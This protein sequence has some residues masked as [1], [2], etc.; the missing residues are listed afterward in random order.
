AFPLQK[1]ARIYR[2]LGGGVFDSPV[3]LFRTTK[4]LSPLSVD[5][6]DFNGDGQLDLAVADETPKIYLNN[7]GTF[8]QS[9]PLQAETV[10][11]QVWSMRAATADLGGN[12]SL[13]L[14]NRDAPSLLFS[15]FAP[16]LASSLTPV[17]SKPAGSLAWGDA[18]KNGTMDLLLGAGPS[19]AQGT[20]LYYNNGGQY[21]TKL[22]IS[23]GLGPQSVAFGDVNGDGR[24]DIAV[25]T[26][27]ENR[28][29][30]AGHNVPDWTASAPNFPT[31][32]VAFIDA[33]S[34]GKLDLLAGANGAGVALYLNTGSML[35]STPVFVT[36]EPGNV[37][38][39]AVAD[40][41]QDFYLDFAVAFYNQPVRLYRNNHNNTFTSV[42]DSGTH[43]QTTSLAW[44]DYNHDGYADL[45]VGNFEQGTQVYENLNGSLPANHQP[46]WTSPTAYRTT[47]IAWGDW[48]YDGYADL[49]IGNDNQPTQVFGNF[50]SSVGLPRLFWL[51][52]SDDAYQTTG[53]AWGD[54]DGDGDLDLGLSQK[55]SGG[56]SGFYKNGNITPSHLNNSFVPTL[57]LPNNPS[58]VAIQRPGQTADGYLYSTSELLGGPAQPTVTVHYT[59]Y[60]PDGSRKSVDLDAAGNNIA[61][62]VF[63]FSLDGGSTWKT[64]S[65]AAGWPGAATATSRL[66]QD[67]T[68]A[69]DI[70]KDQAISDD[71]RFRVR[72]VPGIP[73]GPVQRASTTAVSP[74]FRVRGVTCGWPDNPTF[75]VSPSTLPIGT[76]GTFVGAISNGAGQVTFRWN[77]GDGS[78]EVLGQVAQHA[79]TNNGTFDVTLTVTGQPCPKNREVIAVKPVIAGTGQANTRLYL[80][81]LTNLGANDLAAAGASLLMGAS[82]PPV[83]APQQPAPSGGAT[84]AARGQA[85]PLQTTGAA[86]SAP[87]VLA[88]GSITFTQVTSTN[89]GINNEPSLNGNG[90]R[91]A[92]WSTADLTGGNPDGNIEVFLL[93]LDSG[94]ITFTQISNSTGS[95]LGGFNLSPS[96]DDAG[97][98]IA[99]FS[100]RDL[101]GGNPDNN[102]EIF[103]YAVATGLLS[104]VTQT[105]KGYNILPAMSGNGQYI[106]FVSDRN[107]VGTNTDGNIEVFR[108]KIQGGG[109]SYTQVTSTTGGVTD[110]PSINGDGTR[111]AFI[112][113]QNLDA[114]HPNNADN[115]REVFLAT[116]GQGGQVSFTQIS[117]TTSGSVGA[118]SID[119]AGSRVTFVSNRAPGPLVSNPASVREVFLA[120]IGGGGSF[121]L[122]RVTTTTVEL[123]NDQPSISADGTRIGFVSPGIGQVRV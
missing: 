74:P 69:W 117:Q 99:F 63:E 68:F 66:G 112:S 26:A 76:T 28:L 104:Q 21:P 96:I 30:L 42:W 110:E 51:W 54:Y 34:D 58:Y 64:A 95:I 72:I 29:Y 14:T 119:G 10:T 53:M 88:A 56:S 1:E 7:L 48:D 38:A 52:S 5:W 75:S 27:V 23:S 31:H 80:P 32:Q 102:F 6:G 47:S 98:N 46:I 93:S 118:P 116:I 71:A 87:S 123:G 33:N 82:S 114:A 100:D 103:R 85:L 92:F 9:N 57:A 13:A 108:A 94:G 107:F 67:A 115:N 105:E 70:V 40:Y 16:H 20:Q 62:T 25:G 18:D 61:K 8:D 81:V 91:V 78:P 83:N 120:D 79:Y 122:S 39:I 77:F 41:N 11:G 109:I 84:G 65:A 111:I 90:S 4:F 22:S 19:P 35:A 17:D 44:A 24:L 89:I 49:A 50:A 113:T 106:A 86:S 12:L 97:N 55:G 101:T 73:A 60:D 59:L 36:A 45:A 121:T 43:L 15:G 2:N 37:R 3:E